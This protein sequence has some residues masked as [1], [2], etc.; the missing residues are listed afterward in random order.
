MIIIIIDFISIAHFNP[1]VTRCFT[2]YD[3][4]Q[5][6]TDILSKLNAIK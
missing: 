5:Y 6:K 4:I 2:E 1:I 3:G